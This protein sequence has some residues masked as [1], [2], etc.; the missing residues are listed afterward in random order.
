MVG[1]D[2]MKF[3]HEQK[4][5]LGLESENEEDEIDAI[6]TVWENDDRFTILQRFDEKQIDIFTIM[7]SR[8]QKFQK[9]R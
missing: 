9:N 6:D 7:E 8:K 3:T 2:D 4:V 5:T 1:E